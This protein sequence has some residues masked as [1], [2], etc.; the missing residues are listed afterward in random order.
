MR[1][2]RAKS[3]TR[4]SR[5][6]ASL[7]LVVVALF[8]AVGYSRY[9]VSGLSLFSGAG[10]PT[11][12]RS[13]ARLVPGIY[14]LGGLSPSVAYVVETSQGLVLV[15]S[16]L[17]ADA[18]PLKSQMTSL[19][20]DWKRVYAIL[21]THTHGDHSGGAEALRTATGA[22]VYAGAG[23]AQ[24]L[25]DGQSRAAFF[26]TYFM[27]DHNLHSTTV[28]VALEGD[29]TLDF[30][31][32]RIQALA[33]PG[34]T[35]GSVCYLLERETL[36]V[37]F[38]GDVIMMLRGDEKP[39]TEYR[40]PLG[41]Y[42]AYLAPR[43]RGNASDSL[44]SLRRLRSLPVPDL[45]LPGHPNADPTPESPCLSQKRWESLLDQGINDM[46]K[47]LARYKADGAPFLDG[48]PKQLLPDM[49]YLGDLQGA[50][51]YGFFASSMFFIVDAPGGPGLLDFVSARLRQLGREPVAPAAVLLTSCGDDETAGLKDLMEKAHV[52]VVASSP[53]IERLKESCPQG[54]VF[55][56]AEEL[57][58]KG[59]FPVTTFPLSG[60]GIAPCAYLLSSSGKTVLF[61]GK[62][63]AWLDQDPE[64][65]LVA[66]LTRSKDVLR[67]YFLS[68]TQL[69]KL[70]PS[71]WLPANSVIGQNANLYD[72]DWKRIIENNLMAIKYLID[73]Y[74]FL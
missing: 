12:S 45:V 8:V 11:L 1:G 66:E 65:Q 17:D 67:G 60:R 21:L 56:A 33:M 49:Y 31:D 61:S 22:K 28:D 10:V 38:A 5:T 30:G 55:I 53:A 19:G 74:K 59:W 27:P 71:L 39:R 29:E 69:D 70:N 16:G 14:V 73:N 25:K 54:T 13:A 42:S 43:Y 26:G 7:A 15:D 37:L 57:P 4:R 48:V 34:H 44:A 2:L 9:H 41:T 40:K 46:E 72:G 52:Q 18:G 23:D 32:V 68:I 50:C 64:P 58:K 51:V 35:P 20:L 3:R 24:I 36:R 6:F 62:I 47:L 63:P